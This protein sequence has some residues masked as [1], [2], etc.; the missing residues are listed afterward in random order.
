[1]FMCSFISPPTLSHDSCPSCKQK[2]NG[3]Y[4]YPL[5]LKDIEQVAKFPIHEMEWADDFTKK[6]RKRSESFESNNDDMARLDEKTLRVS[7]SPFLLWSETF[8]ENTSHNE[9][10]YF[11]TGRWSTAEVEYTD[12]LVESFENSSLLLPQGVKLNEFLRDLLMCKT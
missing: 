1:M 3:F 12:L 2:V 5:C 4:I 9:K 8:S 11:R 6:K 7:S 10:F